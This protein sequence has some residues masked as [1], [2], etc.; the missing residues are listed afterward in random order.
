MRR[1]LLVIASLFVMQLS[2]AAFPIPAPGEAPVVQPKE[3]VLKMEIDALR[4]MSVK[5]FERVTGKKMNFIERLIF[6]VEKKRLMNLLRKD[7][8][9]SKFNWLAF[10]LGLLYGP[11]GL[12][13]VYIFSKNTNARSSAWLGFKIWLVV[14]GIYLIVVLAIAGGK[15]K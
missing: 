4:D 8:G 1:A 10:A 12:L 5:D 11:I 6:K 2:F 13:L 15:F 7:D 14:L 3:Q 9:T